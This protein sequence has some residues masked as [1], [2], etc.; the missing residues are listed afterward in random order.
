MVPIS[1][2][3]EMRGR[4]GLAKSRSSQAPVLPMEEGRMNELDPTIFTR[5]AEH[6]Q[7]RAG[8][9]V[10]RWT[11]FWGILGAAL[12]GVLLTPWANW[13]VH[14]LEARLVILLGGVAGLFLGHAFG[15]RR[16][17][18]LELQA[19]L[20]EH[21]HQFELM[22]LARPLAAPAPAPAP[23]ALAPPVLPPEAPPLSAAT[24]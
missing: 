12:G 23:V 1:S 2:E 18:G 17:R 16:A 24:Q 20:A 9:I 8:G 4:Y 6:L 21:Q 7:Q 14:G 22:A 13:P 5:Y 3:N 19:L 11:A 10:A 15:S